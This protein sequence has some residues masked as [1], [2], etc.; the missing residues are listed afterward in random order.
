MLALFSV[1][2]QLAISVKIFQIS[3]RN[4]NHVSESIL[5]S[6]IFSTFGVYQIYLIFLFLQIGIQQA[7]VV[8]S[9][10]GLFAFSTIS[11]STFPT[12]SWFRSN[13]AIVGGVSL[14]IMFSFIHFVVGALKPEVSYD[15]LLYH[16]PALAQMIGKDSLFNWNPISQYSFF[17]DLAMVAAI[18]LSQISNSLRFDD[19][20][21]VQ[22]YVLCVALGYCFLRHRV[23]NVFLRFAIPLCASSATVVWMQARIMYNDLFFSSA[24]L[25]TVYMVL[26]AKKSTYMHWFATFI[27]IAALL[28]SKPAGLL[29]TLTLG[30]ILLVKIIISKSDFSLMALIPSYLISLVVG[31]IFYFRNLV[32]FGNPFYPVKFTILG[33]KLDG[34]IESSVFR[35]HPDSAGFQLILHRLIDFSV[36]LL[37]GMMNGISKYDYDPRKGGFGYIP[38]I[39]LTVVVVHSFERFW[40]KGTSRKIFKIRE[41]FLLIICSILILVLQPNTLEPRYVIASYFL[42]IFIAFRLFPVERFAFPLAFL[43]IAITFLQ[44]GWNEVRIFTGMNSMFIQSSGLPD[45]WKPSTSG[46]IFGTGDGFA[47]LQNQK[48]NL[49]TIQTE[50]GVGASG[51]K[52]SSRINALSYGVYGPQLCNQLNI[53]TSDQL[54]NDS[55]S[56]KSDFLFKQSDYLI[57]YSEDV[58]AWQ[59]RF[60]HVF[61]CFDKGTTKVGDTEFPTDVSIFLRA[62]CSTSAPTN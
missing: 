15:G 50:G 60:S 1:F 14:V 27:S 35:D 55:I 51:M 18:P 43:L 3:N 49:I 56:V 4:S 53:I 5:F 13:V 28:S 22:S 52:E 48:C 38:W 21:Q 58:A 26:V 37:A 57:L 10:I 25:S 2:S 59:T 20:V 61:L 46:S 9:L 40:K 19:I 32:E 62:S 16:G 54:N 11:K 44:V 41:D 29:P 23:I 34:L 45:Q 7:M 33:Y 24:L 12:K 30:T 8:T 36:N 17:P 42:F 6:I 47:Y 31:S 39:V